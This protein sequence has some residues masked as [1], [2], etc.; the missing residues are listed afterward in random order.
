MKPVVEI[1]KCVLC[2]ICTEWCPDVFTL[3]EAGFIEITELENYPHGCI[4]EAA[5]YCPENCIKV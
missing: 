5:M 3:N 4:G 1:D 2:E